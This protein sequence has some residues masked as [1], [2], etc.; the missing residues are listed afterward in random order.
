MKATGVRSRSAL[1]TTLRVM[2]V[3]SCAKGAGCPSRITSN[4]PS[5]T[6]PSGKPMAACTTSGNRSVIN[7]SPRDHIHTPAPRRTSCARIP[8]YFHSTSQLPTSPNTSS[9]LTSSAGST[10]WAKKKG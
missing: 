4:S 8:S 6:V 5:S 10:A 7:S 3:C 1:L 2:R 9:S